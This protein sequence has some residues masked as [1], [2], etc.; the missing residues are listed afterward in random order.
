MFICKTSNT[1]Y[2][3]RVV[4]TTFRIFFNPQKFFFL[5]IHSVLV[6]NIENM[7]FFSLRKCYKCWQIMR[8]QTTMEIDGMLTSDLW[9]RR[10]WRESKIQ[11]GINTKLQMG[12]FAKNAFSRINRLYRL[13]R[14]LWVNI[15]KYVF[16][17]SPKM[18]NCRFIMQLHKW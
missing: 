8:V 7:D 4:T 1:F 18:T 3:F 5:H 15:I 10:T 16:H 14:R 11:L 9:N 6:T 12:Q 17:F 2:E 13:W